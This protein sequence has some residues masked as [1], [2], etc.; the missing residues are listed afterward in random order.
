MNRQN[1]LDEQARG[2]LKTVEIPGLRGVLARLGKKSDQLE[3]S[4]YF[5]EE[6][7]E[8]QIE[9]ASLTTTYII[10]ALPFI[11]EVEEDFVKVD[12]SFSLPQSGFW[13]YR[14]EE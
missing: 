13:V 8:E 1:E 3:I 2:I 5:Q 9:E 14:R 6:P 11:N 4:Y 12:L 10:A 7:S